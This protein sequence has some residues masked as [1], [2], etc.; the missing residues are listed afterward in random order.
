MTNFSTSQFTYDKSRNVFYTNQS[1]LGLTSYPDSFTLISSKT[2]KEIKF[3]KNHEA[4]ERNEWWD[5][6]MYEYE[7]SDVICKNLRV[8]ITE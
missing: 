1:V 4:A 3:T 5:G 6:T 8:V 7:T 2:G